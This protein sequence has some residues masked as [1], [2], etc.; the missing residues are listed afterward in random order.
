MS[1]LK[2]LYAEIWEERPHICVNCG[3]YVPEALAHNFAHIRSKGARPDLKYEKSNI[4]I[5]CSSLD[6]MNYILHR[7][8]CHELQHAGSQEYKDRAKKYRNKQ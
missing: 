5:L 7:Q 3:M 4:E 8:G 6:K 2:K 1:K